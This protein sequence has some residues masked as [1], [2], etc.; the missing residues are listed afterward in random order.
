MDYVRLV[1][2][3]HFDHTLGRFTELAFKNSSKGGGF[4]VFDRACAISTTN[5]VCP[6]ARK[7][8]PSIASDPPVF[9]VIPAAALPSPN[10][11]D[12]TP[13]DTNDLCHREVFEVSDKRLKKAFKATP[14]SGYMICD[15]GQERTLTAA[16]VAS[17]LP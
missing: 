9:L 12:T 17:W 10:R 15:N 4:S 8:Y 6:H 1:H 5:A 11:I 14:I 2:P 3:N 13:S 7:F 16:D